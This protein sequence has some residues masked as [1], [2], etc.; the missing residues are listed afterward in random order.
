MLKMIN[1]YLD[2]EKDKKLIAWLQTKTNRSSYIR[3][4]LSKTIPKENTPSP[5]INKQDKFINSF[6]NFTKVDK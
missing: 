2:T 3:E 1:F 4:V 5:T 6:S